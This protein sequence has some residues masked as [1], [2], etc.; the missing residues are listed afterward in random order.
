MSSLS[1][2]SYLK[3]LFYF[4]PFSC[5]ALLWVE[6]VGHRVSA[7]RRWAEGGSVKQLATLLTAAC[8][9]LAIITDFVKIVYEASD[10]FIYYEDHAD[11]HVFEKPK[12]VWPKNLSS[13]SEGSSCWNRKVAKISK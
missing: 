7:L 6:R 13:S 2:R 12:V 10:F 1:P 9:S 8:Q 4:L 11:D 5:A 3:C